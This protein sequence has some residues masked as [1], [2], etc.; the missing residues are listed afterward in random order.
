VA[1]KVIVAV[2]LLGSGRE[3]EGICGNTELR[4]A[5]PP[6][7]AGAKAY[8]EAVGFARRLP[9]FQAHGLRPPA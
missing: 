9:G 8:D 2:K 1:E 5:G 7:A 3:E 4:E 6:A